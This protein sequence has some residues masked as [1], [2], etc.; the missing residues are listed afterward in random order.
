M[1]LKTDRPWREATE[2]AEVWLERNGY[3]RGKK[4]GAW[5]GDLKIADGDRFDIRIELNRFPQQLPFIFLT[6]P[7]LERRVLPHVLAETGEICFVSRNSSYFEYGRPADLVAESLFLAARTLEDGLEGDSEGDIL[8]EFL[9]YWGGST[10]LTSL[11]DPN[12]PARRVSIADIRGMFHDGSRLVAADSTEYLQ[13]WARSIGAQYRHGKEVGVWLPL[14]TAPE[15]PTPGTELT[16]GSAIEL[17][18]SLASAD[19]NA[20]FHSF[21]RRHPLPFHVL[22][23]FPAPQTENL[24]AVGAYLPSPARSVL[25][26]AR[27]GFRSDRIRWDNVLFASRSR[28]ASRVSISRAD[29]TYLLPR[30]GGAS[31]MLERKVAVAGIGAVGSAVAEL[32]AS[33]GVGEIHL[34]DP[35]D[36][37]ENNVHRHVLGMASVGGKKVESMREL[38]MARFPHLSIHAHPL[39]VEDYARSAL[40]EGVDVVVFATGDPTL[41]LLMSS[42]VSSSASCV[43]VWVEAFGIGG[44]VLFRSKDDRRGCLRCLYEDHEE[45]GPVNRASFFAAGQSFDRTI[46]GCAG[47]FTPFSRLDALRTAIEAVDLTIKDLQGDLSA[48]CLTSWRGDSRLAIAEGYRLSDRAG[49]VQAGCA[50]RDLDFG[51]QNCPDC[52]S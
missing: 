9:A 30:S 36:L 29:P 51:R 3:R 37:E 19:T 28:E 24:V 17:T 45:L 52:G 23:A 25:E 39:R 14:E 43:H 48:P 38:L 47:T 49:E 41:E 42:V 50:V 26:A 7:R 10:N 40:S 2:A 1:I 18:E 32:L 12:G 6:D 31:E 27:R 33:S 8:E 20:F 15:I 16:I 13:S 22:W 21:F 5:I 44:H 11:C 34:V 4:P 46:A 35:E